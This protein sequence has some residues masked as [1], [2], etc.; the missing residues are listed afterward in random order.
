ML[1]ASKAIGKLKM[2]A[3][4]NRMII[5]VFPSLMLTQ[6]SPAAF[7][8]VRCSRCLAIL[9]VLLNALCHGSDSM[10]AP[11]DAFFRLITATS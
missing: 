5:F 4:H 2:A 11:I 1:Q 8:A 7:D 6:G 9:T 3:M 10:L